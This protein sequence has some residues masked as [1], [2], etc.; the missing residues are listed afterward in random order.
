MENS[1]GDLIRKIREKASLNQT[2]FG[3]KIGVVTNTVSAYERG[4]RLPEIDSL[5]RIGTIFKADFTELIKLRV[6]A[7]AN[8]ELENESLLTFFNRINAYDLVPSLPNQLAKQ[9][10][11]Y[12]KSTNVLLESS[13]SNAT[14]AAGFEINKNYFLNCCHAFFHFYNQQAVE[15]FIKNIPEIIDVHNYISKL[16]PIL[17]V[18]V[19]DITT[20][21]STDIEKLMLALSVL[22]RIPKQR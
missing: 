13:H 8:F 10:I 14:K 6:L 7:S 17:G 3:K 22:N 20:L 16:S 21:E 12:L 9:Q 2:D 19:K 15:G 5:I 11:S 1:L 4:D 18:D